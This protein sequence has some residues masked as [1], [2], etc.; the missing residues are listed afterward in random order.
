MEKDSL[1]VSMSETAVGIVTVDNSTKER[2]HTSEAIGEAPQ[3]GLISTQQ[4]TLATS[5]S[6][7]HVRQSTQPS[8]TGNGAKQGEATDREY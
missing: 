2:E 5:Q 7:V 6:D 4:S 8:S 1:V 3:S